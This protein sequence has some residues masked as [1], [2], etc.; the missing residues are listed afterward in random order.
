M[1]SI[2]QGRVPEHLLI[3]IE[4]TSL[5]AEVLFNYTEIRSLLNAVNDSQSQ[6]SSDVPEKTYEDL[7]RILTFKLEDFLSQ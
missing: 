4:G 7:K 1:M 5:G 2:F 3:K 6:S